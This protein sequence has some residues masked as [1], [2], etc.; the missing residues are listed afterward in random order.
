MKTTHL[1][2]VLLLGFCGIGCSKATDEDIE[3]IVEFTIYPET[4][5]GRH[6]LSSTW[7]EDI[8][9]SDSDNDKK[10]DAFH[11]IIDKIKSVNFEKGYQYV[12]KAKKIWIRKHQIADVSSIKYVLL[13]QIKKEKVIT[14]DTEQELELKV[15][16]EL[17]KF[18]PAFPHELQNDGTPKVYD[19]LYCTNTKTNAILILKEI[20]NFN[21]EAGNEYI[22]K[23]KKT[24]KATPYEVSYELL[25]VK[26]KMKK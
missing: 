25:E 16:H 3:K 6:V 20:K 9:F 7:T 19:A 26:S 10:Q 2:I 1:L 13:E 5:Y 24:T 23:V 4:T 22:L 11:T 18:L 8:V 12:Y 14:Q 17:V 21:F 15:G